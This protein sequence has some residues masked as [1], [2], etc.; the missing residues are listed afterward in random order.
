MTS[1]TEPSRS[2]NWGAGMRAFASAVYPRLVGLL[3]IFKLLIP[4]LIL[5]FLIVCVWSMVRSVN[6]EFDRLHAS[7][8]PK[9]ERVEVEIEKIRNEGRRLADRV[10]QIKNEG[11]RVAEEIKSAV[12]PIRRS[13]VAISDTV[14]AISGTLESVVNGIVRV[15]KKIPLV[16]RFV[17]GLK[18]IHLPKFDIPGFSLP[19]LDLNLKLNFD[20]AAVE[21]LKELSGQI[22]DEAEAT[23]DSLKKILLTWWWTFKVIVFLVV[24]WFLLTFIGIL[25]RFWN[26]LKIGIQLLSGHTTT[27]S[28]QI[29]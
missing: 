20:M 7:L 17:G 22:A 1:S 23:I 9:F 2:T 18:G 11:A 29:L 16:R 21:A 3:I 8:Q 12:E 28:L 4:L 6:A 26:K 15:L 19:D 27:A 13:L 24:C 25:A 5:G 10:A 14:R